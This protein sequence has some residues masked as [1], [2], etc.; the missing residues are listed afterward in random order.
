MLN[1]FTTQTQFFTAFIKLD[2][3]TQI[4]F[5]YLKLNRRDKNKSEILK[6]IEGQEYKFIIG[7]TFHYDFNIK[8]KIIIE[9]K[10]YTIENIYTEEN[11]DQNGPF[12][13][14]MPRIIYLSLVR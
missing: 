9:N 7:T 2:D 10:Q 14:A 11:N 5:D 1:L 8:N 3:E 4:P 6:N 12:R 13:K